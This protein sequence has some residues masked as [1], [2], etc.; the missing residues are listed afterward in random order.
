M[1]KSRTI[2]RIS[3]RKKGIE[4]MPPSVSGEQTM[5][6]EGLGVFVL[7]R[8]VRRGSP[9]S[10]PKAQATLSPALPHPM[11]VPAECLP[12]LP[13]P[14]M[15]PAE[16]LPAPPH[17]MIAPAECL[18]TSP[19]PMMSPAECL[20]TSPHPMIV[21][22]ECLPTPPHPMIVPAECL[23]PPPPVFAHSPTFAPLFSPPHSR[24]TIH[25]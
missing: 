6:A 20:P 13:H 7:E 14:M 3:K 19:H 17:P 22:A 23:P 25:S 1:R 21:P 16:C 18:P 9:S 11:I 15:A 24:Q 4:C 12:T 10:A 5:A 8:F 2:R